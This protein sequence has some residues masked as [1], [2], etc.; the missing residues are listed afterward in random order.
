MGLLLAGVISA[1]I[2]ALSGANPLFALKLMFLG[3]FGSISSITDTLVKATPL[4]L[5]GLGLVVS[6]RTGLIS[7]GSE[8]QII[9]GGFT[10]ALCGVYLGFLPGWLLIIA[11]IISG[12]VGGGLWGAIAGY[13]KAQFGV[14]EVINTIM[15]NYVAH[16]LIFFMV[17]G[18]FEDPGG[19]VPQSAEIAVQAYLPMII[20]GTRLH[21]GFVFALISV[22][23]VWFL[24]WRSPLGFQM[25][26]VGCNREAAR[27]S[28]I[29]VKR[30]FVLSMAISGGFA[31]I[32]GM[33]Q[34]GG[35]HHRLISG[36]S[37]GY[38]FDAMAAALLGQ[39]HPIGTVIASVFFGA[40]RM[41]A[42]E[43]Q[44]V[45]Q[46]PVSLVYIV[47]GLIILFVLMEELLGKK[48]IYRWVHKQTL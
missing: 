13:L 20:P 16:Y 8:G 4:M 15:L 22:V 21:L 10:A 48:F 2:I 39:K 34:I 40:L 5:A 25:R 32:A 24:L 17:D 42:T 35:V 19:Y 47:Q 44:M 6:F 12:A 29:S 46:V 33:V 1:L 14:S 37:S 28:G 41:G 3:S 23:A 43:V 31:G 36:F 30:N 26:F 7:I 11:M 38:G 9:V 18:P 27:F 45:L